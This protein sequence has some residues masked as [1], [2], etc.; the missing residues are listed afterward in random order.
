MKDKGANACNLSANT[1]NGLESGSLDMSRTLIKITITTSL[2]K[3][4]E[5]FY[6]WLEKRKMYVKLNPYGLS[7]TA[8]LYLRISPG[9]G[10]SSI[11]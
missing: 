3:G 11:S 1:R 7:C 5:K 2:K 8:Q 10:A 9:E 4:C 6:L